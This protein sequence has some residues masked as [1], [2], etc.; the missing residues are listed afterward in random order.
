MP[1]GIRKR[2]SKWVVVKLAEGRQPER[3][4]G[5]HDTRQAAEAQQRALYAAERR[6]VRR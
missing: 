1:Y 5:V 2:D 3:T 4:M 6:V